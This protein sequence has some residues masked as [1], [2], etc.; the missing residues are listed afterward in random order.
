MLG[1]CPYSK[2]VCWL[3]KNLSFSGQDPF[4]LTF[5]VSYLAFSDLLFSEG[6]GLQ[7]RGRVYLP[8][9]HPDT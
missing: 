1:M 4:Y 8:L 6:R 9:P 7:G 2:S 3:S 5:A